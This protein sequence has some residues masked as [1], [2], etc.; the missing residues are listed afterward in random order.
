M[1]T[2]QRHSKEKEQIKYKEKRGY[3]FVGFY[4]RGI[5]KNTIFVYDIC[6]K[7]RSLKKNK[8]YF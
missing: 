3:E 8:S 6:R 7:I 4:L 2:E 1:A 5:T